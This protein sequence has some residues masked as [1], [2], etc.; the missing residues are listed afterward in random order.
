MRVSTSATCWAIALGAVL[1]PACVKQGC[2][3]GSS[4]AGGQCVEQGDASLDAA[5]VDDAG[6]DSAEPDA[7]RDASDASDTGVADTGVADAASSDGEA[8]CDGG[9]SVICWHDSD[10]DGYAVRGTSKA[11]VCGTTCEDGWTDRDPAKRPDCREGDDGRHPGATETCNALDDDCD[12]KTDEDSG[13]MCAAPHATGTCGKGG[14]CGIGSCQSGWG[15]CDSLWGNGCESSLDTDVHCAACDRYCDPIAMCAEVSDGQDCLC[16]LPYWY[17]L[18]CAGPGPIAAGGRHTCAIKLDGTV[19]CYGDNASGQKNAP[20]GTFTQLAAGVGTTCGLRSDGTVECWGSN[21]KGQATPPSGSFAQVTVSS[22]N[23]CGLKANG[24]VICWGASQTDPGGTDEHGQGLPP[25]EKFRQISAAPTHTCGVRTDGTV[26]CWGQGTTTGMCDQFI[27]GECGQSD[28]PAG[29]F[30][31]VTTGL[32][33][34]CGLRPDGKVECWGGT[35]GKLNMP[36]D[37]TFRV[38]SAG[39]YHTC[40]LTTDGN[41]V[42]WGSGTSVT[43]YPNFGQSV[44]PAG[45]YVGVGVGDLHSCGIRSDLTIYCWGDNTYAVTGNVGGTDTFPVIP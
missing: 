26:A 25:A 6:G 13:D 24:D 12:G 39:R 21:D 34:S 35:T 45:T 30:I 28:P 10:H 18:D 15:D 31:Q 32:F 40:G 4:R 8:P 7:V 38:L 5:R 1:A 17:G 2:P 44:V 29:R 3:E 37:E 11:S 36:T 23:T 33:H 43:S 27:Y 14:V 41:I 22:I 20:G 19:A 42:C 16:P 9:E